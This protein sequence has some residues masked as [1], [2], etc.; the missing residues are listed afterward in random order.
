MLQTQTHGG[1]KHAFWSQCDRCKWHISYYPTSAP[2]MELVQT[3]LCGWKEYEKEVQ[4]EQRIKRETKAVAKGNLLLGKVKTEI[5]QAVGTPASPRAAST[6]ATEW[7][8]VEA[9][10]PRSEA[11]QALARLE[12]AP[13][14]T[15]V[16]SQLIQQMRGHLGA[17]EAASNAT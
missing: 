4:R 14:A 15:E 13:G 6:G 16:T 11:I 8:E 2:G 5:A 7:V 1:N 17:K 10:S 9:L 3:K 12:T